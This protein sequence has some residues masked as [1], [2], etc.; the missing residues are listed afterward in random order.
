MSAKDNDLYIGGGNI[1][2]GGGQHMTCRQI[3]RIGQLL[4]NKG[5]WAVGGAANKTQPRP[6]PKPNRLISAVST[7]GRCAR[8]QGPPRRYTGWS[9]EMLPTPC[10]CVIPVVWVRV[11]MELLTPCHRAVC[12]RAPLCRIL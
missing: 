10:V 11:W 1:S 12:V 4:L 7:W 8:A 2:A 6:D 9:K 5:L 3:A